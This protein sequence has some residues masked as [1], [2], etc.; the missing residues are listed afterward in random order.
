[1]GL[2]LNF[3]GVEASSGAFPAM[4]EGTYDAIVYGIEVK[5][6]KA[7]E[8]VEQKA[9][10]GSQAQYLNVQYKIVDD[11]ED[12]KYEGRFVWGINS[13]RFPADPADDSE[14]ERTTRQMFL[15]WLNTVT[16]TDFAGT[17]Q[18]L[19]LQN[20]YGSKVRLVV[21][22]RE[23]EGDIQNNVK[24]VLAPQDEDNVDALR[25]TL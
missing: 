24:K 25:R 13:I 5:D 11:R 14:K 2:D 17:N 16:G 12:G 3:G 21:T 8:G 22:Q 18:E 4:P 1:M 19:N 7:K 23:Y 9:S 20:L 10:D 15:N 6:T